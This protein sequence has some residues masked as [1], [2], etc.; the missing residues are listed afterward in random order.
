M[1]DYA[2]SDVEVA[3]KACV[4]SGMNIINDFSQDNLTEAVVLR[5]IYED[6]VRDSLTAAPWNFATADLVLVGRLAA[7]PLVRYNAAYAIP[8][9]GT[10]LRV[11]TIRVGGS[12]AEYDIDGDNVYLDALSTDEVVITYQKRVAEQ[13]WPPFFVLLVVYQLAAML[14][15]SITRNAAVAKSFNELADRQMMLARSRDS[16]QVTTVGLNLSRFNTLRRGGR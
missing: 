12:V 9:D 3:Q 7:A 8:Q 1:P 5:T 2:R 11:Q 14:S 4:L 16:Q 6:I 10:I 15:A 13:F